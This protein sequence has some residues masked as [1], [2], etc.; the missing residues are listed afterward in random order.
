[1]LYNCQISETCEKRMVALNFYDIKSLLEGID[2]IT[3]FPQSGRLLQPRS[4]FRIHRIK[5]FRIYYY[6]DKNFIKIISFSK[7]RDY[8]EL[9]P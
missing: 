1:M 4:D 3:N 5:K 8:S 9:L 7:N 6:I 2:F